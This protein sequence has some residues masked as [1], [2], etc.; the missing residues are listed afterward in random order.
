MRLN[1]SLFKQFSLL[2][3]ELPVLFSK[4][5]GSLEFALAYLLDVDSVRSLSKQSVKH[6]PGCWKAHICNPQRAKT[7]PRFSETLIL[8]DA[9]GS[10]RLYGTVN[11]LQGHRRHNE[12]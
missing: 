4:S 11:D 1:A 8:T 6:K 10:E 12:L 2:L 9:F 7:R 3:F 5:R